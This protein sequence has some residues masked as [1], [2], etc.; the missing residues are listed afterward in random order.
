MAA[1]SF[2]RYHFVGFA[3]YVSPFGMSDKHVRRAG[4]AD[5]GSRY[6]TGIRAAGLPEKVLRSDGDVG[7]GQHA[8][9]GL[10]GQ[11]R[12]KHGEVTGGAIVER[13]Q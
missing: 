9:D 12:G 8:G 4:V 13:P 5:H 2:S 6:L 1:A 10:D 3:D 7:V 11:E